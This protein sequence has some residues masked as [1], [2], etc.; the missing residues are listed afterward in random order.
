MHRRTNKQN[1]RSHQTALSRNHQANSTK[2]VVWIDNRDVHALF[3]GLHFDLPK[4]SF[5]LF[6]KSFLELANTLA[7]VEFSNKQTFASTILLD[8]GANKGL[9]S[10]VLMTAFCQDPL[11]YYQYVQK[12]GKFLYPEPDGSPNV[13]KQLYGAHHDQVSDKCAKIYAF[14]PHKGTCGSLN[15]SATIYSY[16]RKNFQ[17]INIGFADTVG[18]TKITGTAGDEINGIRNVQDIQPDVNLETDLVFIYTLDYWLQKKSDFFLAIDLQ[19]STIVAA[20]KTAT[21]KDEHDENLKSKIL[22][23]KIDTEGFEPNVIR[24]MKSFALKYGVIDFFLFEYGD[25]WKTMGTGRLTEAVDIFDSFG[26][27]SFFIS[28]NHMIPIN[29][30]YWKNNYEDYKWKDILSINRNMKSL[31][32]RNDFIKLWTFFS[33]VEAKCQF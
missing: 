13:W 1:I 16:P 2:S 9:F 14:E 25:N 26:Y 24:G 15:E 4:F 19:T 11:I 23:A 3:C 22:F 32:M 21:E 30:M 18:T 20:E 28:E 27:D 29:G 8:I 17:A 5:F 6:F 7:M 12:N 31:Q 33:K 10:G